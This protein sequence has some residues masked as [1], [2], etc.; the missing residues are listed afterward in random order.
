MKLVDMERAAKISGARFYFLKNELVMLNLA[1]QRFALEYLSKKGFEII[2]PPFMINKKAMAGVIP[3]GD[4][5]EVIYKIEDEDLFLI[6]TAEHPLGAMRMKEILDKKELPVKYAGISPC[7]RKEA[8]AHGKDTKGIFRVHQFDKIEQFIFCEPKD[9]WKLHEELIKNAEGIFKALKVPYRG[10]N[11]CT[12]D[13]G[14]V[15]A[16]KYDIEGWFPGQGKYRELCSCSNCT[17]Y[18]SRR[19]AVKYRPEQHLKSEYVHTL[20]STAIAIQRAI[21]CIAENYQTKK[22]FKIPKVLQEYMG[23]LKE[24]KVNKS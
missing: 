8:G 14:Y 2:E 6:A 15:A 13:V 23:G 9:S 4:F 5:E 21:C 18:Q 3:M 7:F 12:G 16:K 24:V 1:L 19:L 20:N 22:G 10:V 11:I 17:D